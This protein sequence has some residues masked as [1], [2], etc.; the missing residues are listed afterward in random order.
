MRLVCQSIAQDAH[1]DIRAFF[2]VLK[3]SNEIFPR[4]QETGFGDKSRLNGL[5]LC[6]NCNN[7]WIRNLITN[8]GPRCSC[9]NVRAELQWLP[10]AGAAAC[11][12]KGLHYGMASPRQQQ[13]LPA[14]TSRRMWTSIRN[15]CTERPRTD[16]C[17]DV[18]PVRP[19]DI[20]EWWRLAAGTSVW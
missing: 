11:G 6:F 14:L 8:R 20:N 10:A 2:S 5:N 13:L 3:D 12:L 18:L 1:L 9:F 16:P 17:R 7:D 19:G 15:I 4:W